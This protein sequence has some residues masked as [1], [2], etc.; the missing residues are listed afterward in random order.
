MKYESMISSYSRLP[1]PMSDQIPHWGRTLDIK[2]L[3]RCTPILSCLKSVR[4][5]IR[6]P[7]R[8]AKKI[9]R[10]SSEQTATIYAA[11]AQMESTSHSSNMR[12][13][14]K[15]RQSPPAGRSPR[16]RLHSV[17]ERHVWPVPLFDGCLSYWP[18][19]AQ[20]GIL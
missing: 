7:S 11:F 17:P 19:A 9:V 10:L 20:C 18:S 16:L 15:M 1:V 12:I 5:T 13:S 4:R 2:G 14:V 6:Y 8:N 3:L